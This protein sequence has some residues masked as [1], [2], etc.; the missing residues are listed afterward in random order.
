MN[1][2]GSKLW[3]LNV[4]LE[5]NTIGLYDAEHEAVSVV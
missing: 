5:N 4:F 3:V 2:E 1:W